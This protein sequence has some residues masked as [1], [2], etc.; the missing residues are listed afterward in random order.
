M[1][2]FCQ[3]CSRSTSWCQ[4]GRGAACPD[5]GFAPLG[6]LLLGRAGTQAVLAHPS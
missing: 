1:C 5:A 2:L 4:R 6:T 3:L